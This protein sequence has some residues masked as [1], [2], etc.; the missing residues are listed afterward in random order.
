MTAS[1][2][3]INPNSEPE[4]MA[5]GQRL[6][7]LLILHKK[8]TSDETVALRG[9]EPLREEMKKRIETLTSQLANSAPETDN[10]TTIKAF[11][12]RY[13][14]TLGMYEPNR[15]EASAGR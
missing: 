4:L 13:A 2:D 9:L 6:L 3:N 8:I 15:K 5:V 11:A 7:A 14:K 1:N 12:K 10:G